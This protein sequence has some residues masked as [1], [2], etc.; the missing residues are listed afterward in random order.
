M[1]QTIQGGVG[2]DLARLTGDIT[3]ADTG[4]LEQML[5][6]FLA[7]GR[8]RVILD[9]S[10]VT[11]IGSAGLSILIRYT[12]LFRN[13]ER[14]DLYLAALSPPLKNL[15]QVAGL[16]SEERSHFSI[17]P[18]VNAAQESAQKRLSQ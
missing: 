3:S 9:L 5:Q 11:Y 12:A 18:T 8:Y 1:E 4:A 16:L 14:G 6:R 17:F 2:W 10:G 7:V 13:W 15:L